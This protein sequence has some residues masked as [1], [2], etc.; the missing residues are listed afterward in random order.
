MKV[1]DFISQSIQTYP[2]LYKDV[3]YERSKLKVLCHTFFTIGNGMEMAE[4]EDPKQGGYVVEPKHKKNEDGDWERVLDKPYG[5]ERYKKLPKDYFESVI[6]YVYGSRNPI[7]ITKKGRN[8]VYFRYDKKVA[9]EIFPP[10]LY[11]AESLYEFSPYP[12]SENYSLAC[13]VY[14]ENLFLQDDWMKE[15]VFLCKRTLEY[16]NDENQYKNDSRY[17]S[18]NSRMT[19]GQFKSTFEVEGAKGV[20]NLRKLWGYDISDEVP[21]EDE[22]NRRSQKVWE[23]FRKKQ[24]NFLTLFLKK[25][26]N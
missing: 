16:F 10:S 14:Y 6:F 26:G 21:T 4:T 7:E 3:D 18:K 24:I 2:S 5:K 1:S 13:K 9:N 22:I 23:D 15:L 11:K 20:R 17:P 19:S 8:D 12:F 25:F